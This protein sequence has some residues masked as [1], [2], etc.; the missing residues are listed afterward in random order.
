MTRRQILAVAASAP[1]VLSAQSAAVATDKPMKNIGMAPTAVALRSRA[2]RQ[3]FD[4]VE[5]CH[6]L[7]LGSAQTRLSSTEPEALKSFR[8]K[9]EGY[10]MRTI[11]SAPLPKT[12]NDIAAYDDAVKAAKE[13]GA[14]LMH[15]ALTGRRYEEYPTLQTFKIH[16]AQ[17]QKMVSLAE[18]ILRKHKMKLAVENHKGWRAAEQAEWIKRV[19]SEYIGVCF[20]FGN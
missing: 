17:C 16:F 12:E 13:A 6:T 9:A 19:G 3:S 1:A 20:D 11:L 4:M 2:N 5:H 18:P 8:A 10:N 15:A 14:I 7:G